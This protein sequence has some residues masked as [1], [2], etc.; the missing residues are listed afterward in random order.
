MANL[1]GNTTRQFST[2]YLTV[3]EYKQAP[4]AIDYDNLVSA[5]SDPTVQ[6]A[7]LAN[8]IARASSAMDVYCNQILGSTT[9]IEQQRT[10]LRPDGMIA[11]HCKNFPIIELLS[12][13]YGVTP[14]DLITYTDP[15]QGWIEDQS[16]ILPYSTINTSYSSQG[17]LQF[18]MPAT[19][20]SPVFCRYTYVN[21]YPTTLLA[22]SS[23]ASATTLQLSNTIGIIAGTQMTIY[24]GSKTENVTV[25]TV[26]D[27]THVTLTVGTLYAHSSGVSI[28][29][30]PPAVKE[31]AILMTTAFLKVRGDNS[32]V[33]D[34]LSSPTR[35]GGHDTQKISSD[36]G[37]A[38][39]LLK[40][41]RRIR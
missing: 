31:A 15:S 19:P 8:V 28:S 4:T 36:M 7:E 26:T 32:M 18:G 10:R 39:E 41:F 30:L 22:A 38:K 21:G 12:F 25:N 23:S 37:L 17:P 11:V 33:M 14:N 27:A 1:Y 3:A 2:P 35:M 24:D 13:A 34:V 5:S 40:P 29:A 16:I 9:D 6:D 20:R